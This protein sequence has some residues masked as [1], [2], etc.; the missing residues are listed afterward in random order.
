MLYKEHFIELFV[1]GERLEL[2]SQEALDIRFND[3]LSDPTKISR[4]PPEEMNARRM[5]DSKIGDSTNVSSIGATGRSAFLKRKPATP[6]STITMTPYIL[7][8]VA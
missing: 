4:L 3:V 8:L 1:N 7:W 5:F 6:E 2:E